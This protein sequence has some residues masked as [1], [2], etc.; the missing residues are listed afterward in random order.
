MNG[1]PPG[2]LLDVPAG[3]AVHVRADA[4]S[5]RPFNRLDIIFQ[6]QSILRAE[7]SSSPR[8][9]LIDQEVT[10][11]TGG[12]LAAR[13]SSDDSPTAPGVGRGYAHTSPIYVRVGGVTPK[14]AGPCVAALLGSLKSSSQWIQR[15]SQLI[16]RDR[17]LDIIHRARIILEQLLDPSGG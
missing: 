11:E 10:L 6:G 3:E 2:T 8:T 1:Q 4:R 7:P 13:C 12:W 9:A 5:L 15:D 17:L 16:Q 14:P